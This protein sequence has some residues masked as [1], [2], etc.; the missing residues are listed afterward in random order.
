MAGTTRFGYSGGGDSGDQG[1]APGAAGKAT[2]FGRDAHLLRPRGPSTPGSAPEA[3]TGAPLVPA[4][5][6][7]E[8]PV[9]RIPTSSGKSG[10]PA[11]AGFWGRRNTQGE[12][13]PAS[14]TGDDGE[15]PGEGEV[16]PIPGRRL[17]PLAQHALVVLAS[18]ALSFLAV[19]LTLKLREPAPPTPPDTGKPQPTTAAPPASP[20]ST[21][22]VALPPAAA[23]S[24]AGLPSSARTSPP[25]VKRPR[26]KQAPRRA[27]SPRPP[28]DRVLAPS[29]DSP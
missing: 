14:T 1:E 9:V 28:G 4:G 27:P 13:E 23:P 5:V 12:L 2:V 16:P 20:P 8:P 17:P 18:A 6:P 3:S 26:G 11:R 29:F 25:P 22:P 19:L 21:S 7:A 24:A 15:S 10:F